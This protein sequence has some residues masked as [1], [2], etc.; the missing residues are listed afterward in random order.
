[1]KPVLGIDVSKDKSTD[2]TCS[3][4]I[5]EFSLVISS[6]LIILVNGFKI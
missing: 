3:D 4:C 2:T 5:Q 6:S 1:M